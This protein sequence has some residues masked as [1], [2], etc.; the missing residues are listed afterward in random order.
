MFPGH[1]APSRP[2]SQPILCGELD[3]VSH[4]DKHPLELQLQSDLD[5]S[6]PTGLICRIQADAAD[7]T[8]Q[9]SSEHRS[10]A[11]EESAVQVAD[12]ITKIWS[13][14]DVKDIHSELQIY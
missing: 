13:I 1:R 6:W 10:R 4:K 9:T 11:A 12:G 5:S 2:K 7:I 3:L 14:E 8:S